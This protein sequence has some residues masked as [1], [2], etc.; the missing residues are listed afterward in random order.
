MQSKSDIKIK[1]NGR[2]LQT[3]NQSPPSFAFIL[4]FIKYFFSICRNMIIISTLAGIFD[5]WMPL[6]MFIETFMALGL[7]TH[8][9]HYFT[10]LY[11]ELYT[12]K[13]DIFNLIRSFIIGNSSIS[14]NPYLARFN[15]TNKFGINCSGELIFMIFLIILTI[16]VKVCSLFIKS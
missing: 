9:A 14:D 6:L 12:N 7:W 8:N 16:L 1:A 10:T 5:I 15:L 2:L 13:F 11:T 4:A 3:V